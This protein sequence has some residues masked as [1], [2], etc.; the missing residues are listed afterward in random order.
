M[1]TCDPATRVT[2]SLLGYGMIAGPLY[3]T[4]SLTQAFTRD[5][6]DLTRH[7]WSMLSNG[8]LGWIQITNFVVTGL[9]MIAFAVGLH[10]ALRPGA[11]STWAPRLIAVY[12]VSMICAGILRADPAMGFPVGTP[13]GPGDISWH[14]IGHF[15]SGGIGFTCLT[16][17]CFVLARRFTAERLTGWAWFSRTT[18]LLFAAGFV[19]VAA[20]AGA[21]WS[22][23]AFVAAV[24]LVFGWIAAV[25]A[26]RYRLVSQG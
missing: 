5:G 19:S 10:R 25:A 13:D 1:M 24:V 11:G 14:G 15:L 17:A 8:S 6:F 12:G 9:M 3:V 22:I 21:S 2:K 26:N 23:L 4:V 20:G 7:A 16:V 18:G